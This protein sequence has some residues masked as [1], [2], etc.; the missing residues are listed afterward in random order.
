MF[1]LYSCFT[2][3]LI[4]NARPCKYLTPNQK[5]MILIWPIFNTMVAKCWFSNSSTSFTFSSCTLLSTVNK[6]PSRCLHFIYLVMYLFI[7]GL[8]SW[9]LLYFGSQFVTDLAYCPFKLVLSFWQPL[10]LWHNPSSTLSTC[11]ISSIICCR[12]MLC[13]PCPALKS[14]ISPKRSCNRIFWLQLMALS[15]KPQLDQPG[16]HQGYVCGIFMERCISGVQD[17]SWGVMGNELD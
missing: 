15:N 2:M 7:I 14:A 4:S 6:I 11:L 9:L 17:N 10:S 3:Q 13:L 1:S 16:K 8:D 5:S 12:L